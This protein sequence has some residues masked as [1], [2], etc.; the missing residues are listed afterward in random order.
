VVRERGKRRG[1]REAE[2][3]DERKGSVAREANLPVLPR[4]ACGSWRRTCT[5]LEAPLDIQQLTLVQLHLTRR[6]LDNLFS[7]ASEIRLVPSHFFIVSSHE[8]DSWSLIDSHFL[9]DDIPAMFLECTSMSCRIVV[10]HFHL[11]P[12]FLAGRRSAIETQKESI[13]RFEW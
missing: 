7:L 2:M 4:T 5:H 8:F 11:L 3:K 12:P 13:A 1:E 10:C 9:L 6:Q